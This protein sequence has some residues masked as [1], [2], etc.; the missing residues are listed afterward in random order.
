M[1]LHNKD[2]NKGKLQCFVKL[3]KENYFSG[4]TFGKKPS[5]YLPCNFHYVQAYQSWKER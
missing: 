1:K 2:K 4:F 3:Y 5:K